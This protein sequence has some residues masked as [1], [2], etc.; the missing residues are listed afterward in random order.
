MLNITRSTW[1]CIDQFLVYYSVYLF[2]YLMCFNTLTLEPQMSLMKENFFY[3]KLPFLLVALTDFVSKKEI[4]GL[5]FLLTSWSKHTA[6]YLLYV[7]QDN[8]GLR[9]AT[10]S[11]KRLWHKCFP[12]NFAKFLRT[13]LFTDLLRWLL[14]ELF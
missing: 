5:I 12:V 13:P 10:L 8:H 2:N 14:F 6:S 3:K 1:S 4:V 11:K 7:V 9:P